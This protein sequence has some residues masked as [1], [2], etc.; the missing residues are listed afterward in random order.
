MISDLRA[1]SVRWRQEQRVTGNRGSNSP[2]PF[3]KS[4]FTVPDPLLDY[5][6]SRTFEVSSAGR[7]AQRREGDSPSIDPYAVP[8]Q[9]S[10]NQGSQMDI[11]PQPVARTDPRYGQPSQPT[12]GGGYPP[13]N[14]AYPPQSRDRF[15]EPGRS[16]YPPDQPMQDVYAR[17]P[18]TAPYGNDP[19][20]APNYP[21][22]NP[23]M[24]PGYGGYMPA[25]TGFGQQ[26][27]MAPT[28]GDPQQYPPQ[29][30]GQPQVPPSRDS[31]EQRDHRD[32]RDPRDPRYAGQAE[33][34]PRYAYPSPATTVSSVAPREREPISSP[35]Q[36][37]YAPD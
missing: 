12:R 24:P 23:G 10:R 7:A 31:R 32:P 21:D 15:Q 2:I 4:G 1:D 3:D 17:A 6:S 8:P 22:P 5:P 9:R 27:V 30:F 26:P 29:V 16:Q 33:Y 28:R 35:Q 34:D 20:Y 25:T 19:R 14:G 13:E 11:D 18:V 37:G 36:P